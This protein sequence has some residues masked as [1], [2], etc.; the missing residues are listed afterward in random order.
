MTRIEAENE[1][2]SVLHAATSLLMELATVA[3]LPFLRVCPQC[4]RGGSRCAAPRNATQLFDE[5]PARPP[6]V[7]P[8]GG[9]KTTPPSAG[10]VEAGRWPRDHEGGGDE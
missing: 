9:A 4:A 6:G 7:R 8:F 10:A 5:A 1:K 3:D 2:R